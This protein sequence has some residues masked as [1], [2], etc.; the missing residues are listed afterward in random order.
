MAHDSIRKCGDSMIRPRPSCIKFLIGI[1]LL[2]TFAGTA[3][4]AP[5]VIFFNTTGTTTWTVPAGVTAVDYLV[6]AG[7]G[8]GGY[9]GGGGGGAGGFTTGTFTS[10]SGA[11]T[12]TVGAGGAGST[13]GNTPGQNG[14]NS[15]FGS[16]TALG[17]GGGGSGNSRNGLPGGSGGGATATGTPGAGTPGQGNNGGSGDTPGASGKFWG[18]GGGGAGTVGGNGVRNVNGGAGGSGTASSIA[19]VSLTYAG[20]GGG[21]ADSGTGGIGG[22]GGGGNGGVGANPGSNGLPNTGGGGGGGGAPTGSGGSGGS[23]IVIIRYILPEVTNVTPAS[24]PL[25]GGT[26]V[27]ITGSGFT[28]VT[29]VRFGSIPAASYTFV[30]DSTILATSPPNATAGVVDVT[31]TTPYGTSVAGEFAKFTYS[32]DM[33]QIDVNGTISNWALEIGENVDATNLTIWVQSTGPWEVSVYDALNEG[34]PAG[35]AGHM[36]EYDGSSYN[37]SGRMLTNSVHLKD[38]GA[39]SYL[40]L[41]GVQQHYL[42]D[43]ATPVEGTIY[44]VM[45]KQ[46]IEYEDLRLSPPSFYQVIVTFIGS[47]L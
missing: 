45:V 13:N 18:G 5:T 32:A 7:G 44:P 10:V 16:S 11:V 4:A 21:G 3:C 12:V 39:P 14:A 46:E 41:T 35:T 37:S 15:V 23:G 43:V 34:K 36:A 42:S 20:G 19:G 1:V 2:L 22:T 33:F 31:V 17:G 8:G 27:T 38:A 26:N 9:N 28:G 25:E 6:V 24:G 30:S 29:A 40:T 47:T